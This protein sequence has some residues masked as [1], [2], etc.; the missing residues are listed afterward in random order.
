MLG[1][2]EAHSD[3]GSNAVQIAKAFTGTD[4]QGFDWVGFFA[5][6]T[7]ER[8]NGPAQGTEKLQVFTGSDTALY[9]STAPVHSFTSADGS[10]FD[11]ID[12]VMAKDSS[13]GSAAVTFTAYKD[14]LSVGSQTFTATPFPAVITFD[15]AIFSGI[16]TVLVSSTVAGI[17]F[18]NLSFAN[19]AWLAGPGESGSLSFT[20]V[21]L[22]DRPTAAAATKS[23][24]MVDQDG[25]TPLA[26]TAAQLA[27]LK[28]G[29]LIAPDAGN[30]N[31]G[32]IN[33]DY[34]VS[35]ADIDF[36]IEGAVVTA[37]FTV[38]VIDNAGAT[39]E[40]DVTITG[41]GAGTGTND[42]NSH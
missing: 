21:D 32:V 25:M 18:D 34:S 29:F 31:N 42:T 20:D 17:A 37:I 10:T 4:F 36:P 28:A 14:G 1:F 2:D 35:Q 22:S 11:L 6:E 40:Q 27:I 16:D 26:L 38:T 12:L 8:N 41:T 33:W 39:A 23:V 9:L 19:V 7:D 5:T 30:T 3:G 15:A 24:V 13:T